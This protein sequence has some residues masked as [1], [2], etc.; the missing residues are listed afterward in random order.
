[1]IKSLEYPSQADIREF[2]ARQGREKLSY[3]DVGAS[4]SGSP[5]G[6]DLDHNRVCLGH[7]EAVFKAA[8]AG[9]ARWEMFPRPWTRIEPANAAIEKGTVVAML[10][11]VYGL[12]WWNACRIVYTLDE[13]TPIR[14]FG[15]AYG[16]L[17]GHIESG[18]ERFSVE[19]L[20]NDTVWYDMRAFSRPRYWLVRLGYPLARRLQRRFVKQ[21]QAAMKRLSAPGAAA[22]P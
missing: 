11:Q 14:R 2:I 6:Y 17:P 16:T 5:D 7:G 18:E 3:P 9:L 20:A 10:A 22:K 21:S 13:S 4:I 12:W 1:M 8:C 15:F 19:W